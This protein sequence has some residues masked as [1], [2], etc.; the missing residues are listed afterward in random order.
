VKNAIM[1]RY[2]RQAAIAAGLLA[3]AACGTAPQQ[4]VESKPPGLVDGGLGYVEGKPREYYGC[5]KYAEHEGIGGFEVHKALTLEGAPYITVNSASWV[6]ASWSTRE[7]RGPSVNPRR[8]DYQYNV[9]WQGRAAE[10]V[11]LDNVVY[12]TFDFVTSNENVSR[13]QLSRRDGKPPER[14]VSHD[15]S[16]VIYESN[17]TQH[18]N[19]AVVA[20]KSWLSFSIADVLMLAGTEPVLIATAFDTKGSVVKTVELDIQELRDGVAM[21]RELMAAFQAETQDYA[22]ATVCRRDFDWKVYVTGG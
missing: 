10:T 19:T 16:G 1:P 5:S 7:W 14:R 3:L 12:I 18:A 11:S 2:W 8:V 17:T 13:V 6:R 22:T 9:Y 20:V 15:F 21:M 4:A